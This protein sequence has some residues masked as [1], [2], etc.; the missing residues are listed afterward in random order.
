VDP[1]TSAVKARHPKA[2]EAEERLAA[3]RQER[4]RHATEPSPGTG[5]VGA[6]RLDKATLTVS[7]TP[8]AGEATVQVGHTDPTKTR[9]RVN[10]RG[11][12]SDPARAQR[13]AHSRRA[14][15]IRQWCVAHDAARLATFT[16]AV[17]PSLDD[18]WQAVDGL[19][20]RLKA[21][22]LPVLIVV[23]WG[24]EGGRLHFH[25]AVPRFIPKE[26]LEAMWPHGWVDIKYLRAKPSNARTTP[27]KRDNAR[28]CAGYVAGYLTKAQG[29]APGE[30]CAAADPVEP[31]DVDL[32]NRRRYSI[33]TGTVPETIRFVSLGLFEA[34]SRARELCG[35]DLDLVW[36]SSDETPDWRGP[37]TSSWR[38]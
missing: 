32:F 19:R 22:G 18:G 10:H 9:P 24:T 16:F 8:A 29:E 26:Q 28:V 1:A 15:R 11:T 7:V 20:R 27:T 12:A 17:E 4:A 21:A 38:G 34:L 25:G 14:K 2:I 35:H 13:V 3:F 5:A 30:R 31:P 36:F 23:Q 37:P 6:A 33:P